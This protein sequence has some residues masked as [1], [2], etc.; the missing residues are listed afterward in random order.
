MRL[1]LRISLWMINVFVLIAAA[2]LLFT[3]YLTVTQAK[4]LVSGVRER[5]T[6][7]G[8]ANVVAADES[9]A[10]KGDFIARTYRVDASMPVS[11]KVERTTKA[12]GTVTIKNNYTRDQSL[13]KTTRLLTNDGKIFRITQAV[14]IPANGK[15]DVYAEADQSGD[16]YLIGPS[17][18]TIP[19]LWEGLQDSIFADSS[20]PMSYDRPSRALVTT[21]DV[22][23]IKTAL[24][25]KAR[26]KAVSELSSV[27][28]EPNRLNSSMLIVD[29]GTVKITPA[30][31]T[32]TDT[33]KAETDARVDAVIV[34]T[35]ALDA[36]AKEIIAENLDNVNRFIELVPDATSYTVASFDKAAQH[37]TIA[38]TTSAWVRSTTAAPTV[39]VRS[40]A[41]RSK[42]QAQAILAQQGFADATVEITP[43]WLLWLPLLADHITV[44]VK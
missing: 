3:I 1:S 14:S 37:A 5:F 38:L 27:I 9:G 7:D 18:F 24:E 32:E 20:Q 25:E 35:E 10:L 29:L 42:T 12:G 22:T 6:T 21:D 31:G 8:M 30:V 16:E 19:G 41:G 44:E 15:V 39:D 43:R 4:I 11:Q 17:H 33:L 26:T 23:K 28:L 34:T 2:A 36:A 13:V 40:L